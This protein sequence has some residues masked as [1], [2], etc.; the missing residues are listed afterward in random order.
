VLYSGKRRRYEYWTHGAFVLFRRLNLGITLNQLYEKIKKQFKMEV[1]SGQ[2]N[3]NVEVSGVYY[4]EDI[5]ISA[6]TRSGE[7]IM[8]TAMKTVENPKWLQ[9]FIDSLLPYH[10][11]GIL[12]NTGG[13]LEDI[14]QDLIAY[15][16]EK[17]LPLITFPWQVYL[18]DVNEKITNLIYQEK[19]K[20]NDMENG[21][22]NAI[23]QPEVE[24]GYE[25]CMKKL[26]LDQYNAVCILT[27]QLKAKEKEAIL[28]YFWR[29]I[30]KQWNRVYV[31]EN[32]EEHIFLFYGTKDIKLKEIILA[33]IKECKKTFNVLEISIGMGTWVSHYTKIHDSYEKAQLCKKISVRQK[34]DMIVFDDLE[35]VGLL[36]TCN[37]EMLKEYY[38]KYLG[39]LALY[40]KENGTD[41]IHVLAAYLKY[42]GSKRE[43]AQELFVHRNTV[44]YRLK[45]IEEM[46]DTD[47]SDLKEL[48]KY[49]MAV[50]IPYF[51]DIESDELCSDTKK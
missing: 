5:D 14:S 20:K 22:L 11:S 51:L 3:M 36:M 23:F 42:N 19:Q 33:A 15:C 44:S 10:P 16:E 7:L 25:A 49:Q 32:K 35:I 37:Q 38:R 40:D 31:V 1:L 6:W 2:N 17:Q 27:V 45:K 9:E 50:Y 24:E 43:T 13:Y 26:G 48:L 21:I 28:L 46:L 4:M 47:F 39:D 29:L 8:T 34:E 30:L 18:Q 12:V 41:Y